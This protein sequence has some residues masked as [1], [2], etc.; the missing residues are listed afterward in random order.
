[1]AYWLTVVFGYHKL[2]RDDK[3]VSHQRQQYRFCSR[4]VGVTS[5][6]LAKDFVTG[7]NAFFGGAA[8]RIIDG[9][10]EL[11]HMHQ[12]HVETRRHV[13]LRQ[14][15]G[16]GIKYSLCCFH[17]SVNFHHFWRVDSQ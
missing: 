13:V 4:R 11:W 2:I 8:D 6:C 9:P 12:Q 5:A 14:K 7:F 1:M 17:I 3:H 10:L 15:N 16:I